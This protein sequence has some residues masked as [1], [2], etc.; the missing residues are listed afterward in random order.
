[1]G[2]YIKFGL[3]NGHVEVYAVNSVTKERR[4]RSLKL[5][6]EERCYPLETEAD[7]WDGKAESFKTRLT[8]KIPIPTA[9][10]DNQWLSELKERLER[11]AE[12]Q[13]R[14]SQNLTVM[15]CSRHYNLIHIRFCRNVIF[16]ILWQNIRL[17][18][19][20]LAKG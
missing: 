5:F 2:I 6:S 20:T 7:S 12:T 11:F 4:S 15:M 13:S 17:F 10:A 16:F 1:M 14:V 19:I 3:H 8:K 9:E 18:V